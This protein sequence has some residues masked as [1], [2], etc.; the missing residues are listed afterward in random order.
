[1]TSTTV[2]TVDTLKVGLE[3]LPLIAF[4]PRTSI[5]NFP[6]R[7]SIAVK[8]SVYIAAKAPDFRTWSY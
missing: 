1:M 8:G 2:L 4:H 7:L 5:S 3:E 6:N